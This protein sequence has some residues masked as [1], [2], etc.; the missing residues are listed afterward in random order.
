MD[1]IKIARTPMR[2]SLQQEDLRAYTARQ[3]SLFSADPKG[4]SPSRLSPHFEDAL[5]RVERCFQNIRRKYY[6]DGQNTLFNHLHGDQYAIYLYYLSNTVYRSG[7]DEELA[8]QLFLLNKALHGADIFYGVSLPEVFL[9]IHPVG[10]VLGNATY[11]NYFVAY[12]NCGIGSLEDG[13]Y[14]VF[15]GENV[16]FA[17]SAVLGAC[18]LGR[19]VIIGANAFI[20]NTDVPSD[21]TVVGAYPQHRT[22]SHTSS[23]LERMF[24]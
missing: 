24:R 1:I 18:H 3:L 7:K 20:L 14:P 6:F 2:W 22:L 19:N 8:E 16:L 23:V 21:H 4:V 17:C 11:G 10:T 13:Q 9:L 12:Q 15:D 5:A